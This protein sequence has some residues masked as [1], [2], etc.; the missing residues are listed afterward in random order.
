MGVDQEVGAGATAHTAPDVGGC[1]HWIEFHSAEIGP[2]CEA[3]G[4]SVTTMWGDLPEELGGIGQAELLTGKEANRP[5][6]YAQGVWVIVRARVRGGV[7]S[8]RTDNRLEIDIDRKTGRG[9][10][11]SFSAGTLLATGRLQI[12]SVEEI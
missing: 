9:T 12:Y 11:R 3:E 7:D 4:G 2:R 10:W 1:L 5:R 6:N 8:K